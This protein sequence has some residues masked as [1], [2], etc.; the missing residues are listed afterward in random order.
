MPNQKPEYY[1][2]LDAESLKW[3]IQDHLEYTLAKN[4]Y[5]STELD[6]YMALARSVRDRLVE[7][8]L[9][10]QDSYYE[11]DAKR[12]YYLSMEFLMG[13]SLGNSLLGLGLTDESRTA[14]HEF[15]CQLEALREMELDAGLG[16]GG[17][18]RLAA[19]FLDSAA[20]L[21]IP[22]YG[23]GIRYEFGIFNQQIRNGYQIE[24][25]DTWLRDGYPWEIPRPETT[26]PI[27]YYGRVIQYKDRSG[28]IVNEWLDTS[29]ILAMAYDT[30]I[31]GYGNN[32]VNTLRLWS[33]KATREF[34]FEDFNQGDYIRAVR[35]KSESET[36]S[37]VLYPNDSRHSGRELR[38][39]Q[40]Y[41]FASASLQ[42]IIRRYKKTR[43][44][45]DEFPDK[46]AIQLN[47]THP[48]I[49]IAEL[50]RLLV[51][52]E[53]LEWDKAWDITVRT[54]GYTNH[55]VMPE[56]LEKWSVDLLGAV[57]PRHLLIIFEINQRFLESVRSRYP[58]DDARCSR[59]SLIEEP[60]FGST[61]KYV[62][63]AHLAIVGSHSV[64]GVSALH[65]EILK[66][67]IFRD[68]AEMSPNKFNNK[69]NGITQ[70]RWLA[71]C[72]PRLSNAITNRIGGDWITDLDALTSLVPISN[73]AGFR[74]EWRQVKHANKRDLAELIR[75]EVGV[76][77][78][79]ESLIDCQ[80]KRIHDYK[81]QL[82]NAIHAVAL[83]NEIREN[84][85]HDFVP[86][87]VLFGGKAAPGYERAKLTIK[88][89]NSIAN[90]INND[91]HTRDLLKMVFVPNYSV[92]LAEKIIPGADLSVQISTAGYEASGTGNMKFALNGAL[93][94]GTLDG[95]NIEI[96]DEVG[97]ENIFIFGLTAEE[98]AARRGSYNPLEYYE[99]DE[100]L[101]QAL[102]MI[103]SGFFSPLHRHLFAPIVNFLLYEGDPFMVLVDFASF[104]DCQ[105]R[106]EMAYHD[107][108]TWTRSSILNVSHIGK[109]SSDRTIREYA[110]DIWNAKPVRIDMA[111]RIP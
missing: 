12:V 111:A 73:D 100:R 108:D 97:E 99:S 51:D 25:P 77:I 10:T 68:F 80:I 21:E 5:T 7:R 96:R 45:F 1:H 27:N 58:G 55:T 107:V 4:Q 85:G 104:W 30:P 92:T 94:I 103:A 16:N 105:R 59:V 33:A 28:R 31:P 29:E 78:N 91:P 39:R 32:T 69:T 70:R 53:G 102:D 24:H 76:T 35:H 90:V 15:G 82:L 61:D 88:L 93:T 79:P 38:L 56:A 19:C 84:P 23:Y 49:A 66:Q 98:V 87:T 26:F 3:S 22:C 64:N 110:E 60:G 46:V 41:F 52:I 47:D 67:D 57:L 62:R 75:R 13:R 34:D 18:G 44:T 86:R 74:H 106:V 14:L 89:I 20:T 83:Y 6:R 37:K 9:R 101:K 65:S 50:M 54:F 42:D 11:E 36:I 2:G 48:A 109:F 43:T 40:E 8:W 17:L 71:L 63:M 72:N 95:A 81:R